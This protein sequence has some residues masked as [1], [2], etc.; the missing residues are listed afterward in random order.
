MLDVIRDLDTI[1]KQK[2]EH[3]CNICNQR[4]LLLE[5]RDKRGQFVPGSRPK[6]VLQRA[7]KWRRS[8]RTKEVKQRPLGEAPKFR[9]RHSNFSATPCRRKQD[10]NNLN[11]VRFICS[12]FTAY[13]SSMADC[14]LHCCF[15]LRFRIVF[16]SLFWKW[17][18]TGME[19][20]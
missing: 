16:L 6:R 11:C 5:G 8:K 1:D 10:A 4:P 12:F 15:C 13:T 3:E 14:V 17:N 20:T 2:A 18:R 7:P 19:P 9:T